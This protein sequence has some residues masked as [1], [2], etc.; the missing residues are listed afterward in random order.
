MNMSKP[1]PEVLTEYLL[2]Y[3]EEWVKENYELTGNQID[4]ILYGGAVPT[5]ER[6]DKKRRRVEK[7]DS[8]RK[9]FMNDMY[10]DD[11]FIW[12]EPNIKHKRCQNAEEKPLPELSDEF[13]EKWE[14][15]YTS[16]ISSDMKYN[17]NEM[18]Q[19]GWQHGSRVIN[20]TTSKT[21]DDNIQD[22]FLSQLISG[23][24]F[25]DKAAS[26]ILA[27]DH[28]KGVS[29]ETAITNEKILYNLENVDFESLSSE[30][31]RLMCKRVIRGSG[32]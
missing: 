9:S 27:K 28:L 5:E 31:K 8:D 12:D 11:H 29:V 32:S 21:T 16:R 14:C 25:T 30:N 15:D 17:G 3:G 6:R 1:S 26:F 7:E 18:R 19:H 22:F 24:L 13:L 23:K 2:Y 4:D 10:K 20:K